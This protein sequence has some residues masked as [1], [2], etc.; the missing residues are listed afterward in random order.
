MGTSRTYLALPERLRTG[1]HFESSEKSS[2][3]ED[4][5]IYCWRTLI[6]P[7]KLVITANNGRLQTWC[8]HRR[9]EKDNMTQSMAQNEAKVLSRLG[10]RGGSSE[11]PAGRCDD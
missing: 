5:A 9:P 11:M 10:S 6:K 3:D 7:A 4:V 2:E 8:M 1:S